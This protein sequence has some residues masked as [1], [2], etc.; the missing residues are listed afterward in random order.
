MR[1]PHRLTLAAAA[2]AAL[3]GVAGGGV[4]NASADGG[5]NEVVGHDARRVATIDL[6]SP[7]IGDRAGVASKGFVVDLKARFAAPVGRTG[8]TGE[9][10]TGPG[11][12]TNVPPFP[13]TFSAGRD[14]RFPGLIMLLSTT[15]T[16]NA[17]GDP[18]G[19]AG[20]GQ[21]LANLFNVTAVT[22]RTANTTQLQDTWLVGA[23]LFGRN[24]VS[25]AYAAIAAD[26]DGNGVYDDAPAVVPD[27]D[28]DGDVDARDLSAFGV[29]SNI[30]RTAFVIAD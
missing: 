7:R 3:A 25:I 26:K 11:A 1:T 2:A 5:L 29:V 18:T 16:K 9:Q 14:D 8:F 22:D 24:T 28:G 6:V 10:L 20:P 27:A 4:L 13:G 15:Q 17:Q 12:H 23:P 21:N 30:A 19:F